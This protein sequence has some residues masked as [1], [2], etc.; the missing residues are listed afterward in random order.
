MK[1]RN[2]DMSDSMSSASSAAP[3][4][5]MCKYYI[6]LP[7][8]TSR[9][10]LGRLLGLTCERLCWRT[11]RQDLCGTLDRRNQPGRLPGFRHFWPCSWSVWWRWWRWEQRTGKHPHPPWKTES[12]QKQTWLPSSDACD[13]T[14][15]SLA[16]SSWRKFI[17]K[18]WCDSSTAIMKTSMDKTAFVLIFFSFLKCSKYNPS[19]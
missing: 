15:L 10:G 9:H 11:A 19:G 14:S 16:V 6:S 13:M 3:L 12:L 18:H 2:E 5:M 7:S 4:S 17:V 1:A 8:Q